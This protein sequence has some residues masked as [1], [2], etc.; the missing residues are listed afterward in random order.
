[1]PRIVVLHMRFS[2]SNFDMNHSLPFESKHTCHRSRQVKEDAVWHESVGCN[3]ESGHV[4]GNHAASHSFA[5][6]N[7]LKVM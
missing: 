6:G 5:W 7:V 4:C 1:V 3:F 2:F